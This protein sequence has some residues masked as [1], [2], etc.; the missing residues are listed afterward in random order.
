MNLRKNKHTQFVQEWWFYQSNQNQ[1]QTNDKCH[2]AA[3]NIC[4][5]FH[6]VLD[7]QPLLY[8]QW[9][10]HIHQ[11][12]KLR[13]YYNQLNGNIFKHTIIYKLVFSIFCDYS[14]KT[15]LANMSADKTQPIILPK[16]GT[17]LTYGKA[18]VISTF[19]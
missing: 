16:C 10:Y 13:E 1:C 14:I 12:H 9:Q 15:Y 8:F 3:Q 5:K 4:H 18:E 7:F 17:L 19:L 2:Y 6:E 11:Y